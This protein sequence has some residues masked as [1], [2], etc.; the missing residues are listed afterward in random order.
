LT[1]RSFPDRPIVGV[2]AVVLDGDRVL[3]VKRAQEP[4]KGA[5]SL[6]GGA[7]ELGEA[8]EA[9]VARELLEETGLTVDVGPV[10]EVLDRVQQ[11][12]DGRVEYHYVIID[13]L[14]TPRSG[15]LAHASDVAAAAWVDRSDLP[16]YHL[17]EKATAVIEK[18]FQ[19]RAAGVSAARQSTLVRP[20]A[21]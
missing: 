13:Y 3:L 19:I 8:L 2:G 1:S 12:P 21:R 16:A 4:L 14:C 15:T 5:W 18:A 7:V 11:A 17:T 10:V 20:G 6:P 9:A